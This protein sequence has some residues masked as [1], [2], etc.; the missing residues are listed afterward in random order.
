MLKS[1]IRERLAGYDEGRNHPDRDHTS[2]LSP[3]LHFGHLGPHTVALAVKESD[4]PARDREA[5]LEQMIVRRELAINFCRYNPNYD[6]LQCAEPWALRTIE[7]HARDE[8]EYLYRE[9]QLENAETHDPLWNAAQRQM[10]ITGWMHGYLRMYWA[11]KILEWTRSAG[12]GFRDCRPPERPL[13][14]RRARPQRLRGHRLGHCRQARPRLGPGTA[15]LRKNPLHVLPK[16]L[17]QIQQ[18]G[19]YRTGQCAGLTGAR[20]L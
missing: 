11:K 12:G 1:F 16:H 15:R 18:Q 4:A 2:R 3:Y 19:L 8:R 13:R 9:R 10:V 6:N 7:E 20:P 14:T 17:A 5:F